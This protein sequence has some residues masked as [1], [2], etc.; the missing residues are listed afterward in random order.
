MG[1]RYGYIGVERGVN[2]T[3]CGCGEMMTLHGPGMKCR[4]CGA[5]LIAVGS[6]GQHPDWILDLQAAARL[7]RPLEDEECEVEA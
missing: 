1:L 2:L 5:I 6:A 3:R 4:S 7:A